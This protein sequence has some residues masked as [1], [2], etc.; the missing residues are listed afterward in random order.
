MQRQEELFEFPTLERNITGGQRMTIDELNTISY[1]S[2][3]RKFA[4]TTL[5]TQRPPSLKLERE[6][7]SDYGMFNEH[8][9]RDIYNWFDKCSNEKRGEY[10]KYLTE[11]IVLDSGNTIQHLHSIPCPALQRQHS[12]SNC[13]IEPQPITIDSRLGA[14]APPPFPESNIFATPPRKNSP[15]TPLT[16]RI[17]PRNIMMS[18]DYISD[19][20]SINVGQDSLI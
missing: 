18:H 7:P 11:L 19:E 8:I 20:E 2:P 15:R 6:I 17:S 1:Q 16:A 9:E 12:S 5:N 3:L 14:T 10:I 13:S 4:P